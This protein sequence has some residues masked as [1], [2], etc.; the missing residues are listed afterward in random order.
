M[1]GWLGVGWQFV[2]C[3]C[4]FF[5]C[6]WRCWAKIW[7]TLP[8]EEERMVS[9]FSQL[10]WLK[11]LHKFLKYSFGKQFFFK[12]FD[13]NICSCSYNIH[14]ASRFSSRYLT[15]IFVHVLTIF[16]KQFFL[17]QYIWLIYLHLQYLNQNNT[18]KT[19]SLKIFSWSFAQ[20]NNLNQNYFIRT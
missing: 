9:R 14:L 12:I 20:L 19:A 5:I 18:W 17:S 1:G 16:G 13:S 10:F 11:Y 2:I 3:I 7:V 6:R 4:I 15:E 8:A